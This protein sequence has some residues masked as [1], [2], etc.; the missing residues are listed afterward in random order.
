MKITGLLFDSCPNSPICPRI[1]DTDGDD[2]IVQGK[3][4]ADAAVRRAEFDVPDD[5]DLLSFPRNLLDQLRLLSPGEFEAVWDKISPR[6]I[7]RVENRD[8]YLVDSDGDDFERFRDGRTLASEQH[9]SW[10]AHLDQARGQG[11][12]WSRVR[13]FRGDPTDYGLYECHAFVDSA[14][15]GEQIR[16]V[17]HD[18]PDLIDVPDFHVL[19]NRHVLRLVYDQA[20]RHLGA[21]LVSGTDAVVYRQLAKALYADG[22][23]FTAW[24][25]DH[26]QYHRTLRAA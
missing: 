8:T 6:H 23:D 21:V 13:L 26:P 12:A 5:E 15:H 7:L 19:D 20:G 24:W 1:Y 18:D 14:D 9:A 4:L 16:V 17:Q 10:L 22:Q 3:K 11:V 2:V 25:N